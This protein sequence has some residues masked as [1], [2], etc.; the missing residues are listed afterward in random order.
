MSIE[1]NADELKDIDIDTQAMEEIKE[2]KRNRTEVNL[3]IISINNIYFY[4]QLK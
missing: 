4:R 3:F 1:S 2:L